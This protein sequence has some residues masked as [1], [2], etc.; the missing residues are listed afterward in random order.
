MST[1]QLDAQIGYKKESSFGTYATADTFLEFTEEDFN[2]APEFVQGTGFRVGR[3]MNRG[4]RRR[5][6]KQ[7]VTG[8]FTQYAYTKGLGAL[9][10]AAL[11]GTGASNQIGTSSTYQ[12]LLTPTSADSLSSYSIQVGIPPLGG[13]TTLPMTYLGMVCSGFEFS[14]DNAGM[15]TVKFNWM[16]KDYDTS[17]TLASASYASGVEVYSFED[18]TLTVGGSVTAP[19]TTALAT[20]GTSSTI[21]RSFSLTYDNG[22]DSNGFNIGG[23]GKRTRVPALGLRT[24]TGS[25]EA[26]FDGATYRDLFLDQ[27]DTPIT[28]T[29]TGPTQIESASYPTLQF[30]IPMARFEGEMPK[31]NGGDVVTLAMDFTVLDDGTATHPF[32]VAIRTAETAI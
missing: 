16:G 14:Q 25:I 11:G 21:V 29:L 18:A 20:G 5:T 10:E 32:Y 9:F 4:D 19:T 8:S 30:H 15:P 12:Q 28:F 1:T 13:G 3:R 2:W 6:G 27:T 22:L 17:T 24:A 23:A 7:E 31:T 26:E